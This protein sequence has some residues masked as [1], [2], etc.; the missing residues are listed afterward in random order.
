MVDPRGCSE[1]QGDRTILG[2]AAAI[3]QS[4]R[5]DSP[6]A[7]L[8]PRPESLRGRPSRD[9][10]ARP[11]RRPRPRPASR[12]P[13][14]PPPTARALRRPTDDRR[15]GPEAR[16]AQSPAETV[17]GSARL[18][19]IQIHNDQV[20]PIASAGARGARAVDHGIRGVSE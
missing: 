1:F 9:A 8:T 14:S 13:P 16:A 3:R 11:A 7:S 12:N 10:P 4:I 17:D 15:I 19:H 18:N 6:N 20:P 2:E 5:D